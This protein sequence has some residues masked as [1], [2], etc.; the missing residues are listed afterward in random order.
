MEATVAFGAVA[1]LLPQRIEGRRCRVDSRVYAYG[2]CINAPQA[3]LFGMHGLTSCRMCR[4]SAC[5]DAWI[6]ESTYVYASACVAATKKATAGGG[7]EE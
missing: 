3:L 4:G 1:F 2:G 7:H 5:A 6:Q